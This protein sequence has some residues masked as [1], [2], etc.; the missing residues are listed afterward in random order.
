MLAAR[1]MGTSQ[2]GSGTTRTGCSCEAPLFNPQ[3]QRVQIHS[4]TVIGALRFAHSMPAKCAY[5]IYPPTPDEAARLSSLLSREAEVHSARWGNGSG[6]DRGLNPGFDHN[7][8]PSSSGGMPNLGAGSC[9]RPL[10]HFLQV[11]PNPH[12]LHHGTRKWPWPW[13]WGSTLL[14][15][16]PGLQGGTV[17]ARP[18]PQ[19][20]A[21]VAAERTNG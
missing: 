19:G 4:A 13:P 11:P 17:P 10:N 16:T 1:A 8:I 12:T 3:V 5:S 2:L 14:G 9:A 20:L 18:S 6:R 21:L 7:F 15:R